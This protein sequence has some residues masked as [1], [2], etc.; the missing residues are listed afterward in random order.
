M[1]AGKQMSGAARVNDETTD[2][3]RLAI[4]RL[5]RRLRSTASSGTW[6]PTQV[7]VLF[8]IVREGPVALAELAERES[9]HPTMLSRV[10]GALAQAGLVVRSADS[11]DR[12]AAQVE[13]TAA[14][15]RLRER[16]HAERNAALA[17][18]LEGLD[19]RARAAVAD[20]LPGL[21]EL[22][23]LLR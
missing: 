3:L 7:S 19:P 10:V 22:A 11:A 4:G 5:A 12:R 9:L 13:A 1:L 6:T 20:A 2:R 8:T 15:R 23:E 17:S 21:E 16:I 18:A 14:G